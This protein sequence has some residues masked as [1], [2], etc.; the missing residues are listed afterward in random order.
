M[1]T[2]FFLQR[3]FELEPIGLRQKHLEQI[4]AS[5]FDLF[6]GGAGVI[7]VVAFAGEN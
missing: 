4:H 7:A 2:G 6:R 3:P 5:A 1:S